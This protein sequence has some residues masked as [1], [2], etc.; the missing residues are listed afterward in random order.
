MKKERTSSSF[1]VVLLL[2]GQH[3]PVETLGLKQ[4]MVP[5]PLDTVTPEFE[6]VVRSAFRQRRKQLVNNLCPE[7]VADAIRKYG[8]DPEK[9]N[10]HY[11]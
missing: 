11:A 4:L 7:P 6:T 2:C 8:I 10:P 9:A 3:L 5:A 1:G